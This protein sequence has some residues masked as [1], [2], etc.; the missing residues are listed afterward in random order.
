MLYDQPRS[1]CLPKKI[2]Q[3][4]SGLST[5]YLSFML[6]VLCARFCTYFKS[7]DHRSCIY[8]VY[9]FSCNLYCKVHHQVDSFLYWD[10]ER[11]QDLLG[12]LGIYF[13]AEQGRKVKAYAKDQI[14]ERNALVFYK[15]QP[16]IRIVI[17]LA[18][19]QKVSLFI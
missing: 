6:S 15:N 8:I 16:K 9:H 4:S 11:R 12:N 7:G 18:N 2:Q 14:A 13:Y 5:N 17:L 1:F 19:L 10:G 3:L